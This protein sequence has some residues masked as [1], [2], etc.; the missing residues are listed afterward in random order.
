MAFKYSQEEIFKLEELIG[1]YPFPEVVRKYN[2]FASRRGC[3]K[4][5]YRALEQRAFFLG[6]STRATQESFNTATLADT[7]GVSR[8]LVTGWIARGYLP[9]RSIK[10]TGEKRRMRIITK[11]H[12]K[13]FK[14]D[15]AHRLVDASLEGL[16]YFFGEQE[17]HR[18]K[19]LEKIPSKGWTRVRHL[20]TG[21]VYNS[22]TD[23]RKVHGHSRKTIKK[24]ALMGDG[25]E[26]VE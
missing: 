9:V 2:I 25:W 15:H 23:A 19:S 24:K 5:T 3:P 8:H 11:E 7:L 13:K 21:K 4:R 12:L 10:V 14:R 6:L 18:I 17:A 26:I 16:A 20:A 22:I 1:D